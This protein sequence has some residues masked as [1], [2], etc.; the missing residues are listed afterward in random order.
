MLCR[1]VAKYSDISLVSD[2]LGKGYRLARYEDLNSRIGEEATDQVRSWLRGFIDTVGEKEA[3]ILL[4]DVGK[5]EPFPELEVSLE[6]V[7]EIKNTQ[8]VPLYQVGD[9]VQADYKGDGHWYWAEIAKVHS[10]GYYNVFYLEDCSEEIATFEGRLRRTG[11]AE[12]SMKYDIDLQ[13][14][15]LSGAS[16]QK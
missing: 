11:T 12:D 8:D 5:L 7:A 3:A 2:L 10:N 15:A 13:E 14:L 4:E 6:P 16:R 9:V 1:K